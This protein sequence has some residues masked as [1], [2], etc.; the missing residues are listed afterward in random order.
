L[1]THGRTHGRWTTDNGPSQKLTLSTL[2]SGELKSLWTTDD[3]RQTKAGHNSSVLRWAKKLHLRNLQPLSWKYA[4]ISRCSWFWFNAA[5][6]D[7][8]LHSQQYNSCQFVAEKLIRTNTRVLG[9][10]GSIDDWHILKRGHLLKHY[11]LELYHQYCDF[12]WFLMYN[13][14]INIVWLAFPNLKLLM[15]ACMVYPQTTNVNW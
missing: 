12:A 3:A 1:L 11:Q 4:G 6:I 8:H 15:K 13:I 9:N 14:F 5:H 2:C 10:S 7:N